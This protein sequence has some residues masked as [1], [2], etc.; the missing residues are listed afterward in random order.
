MK[1]NMTCRTCEFGSNG[2][3]KDDGKD[4]HSKELIQDDI[5]CDEWGASLE[6]YSEITEN[7][8][9]Y[10]KEPYK[11]C[12]ISYGEFLEFLRKDGEGIGININ[13]YDAI[14]RVYDLQPWELAG[15]LDVSMGVI[16]YARM[17]KTTVKRKRQFSS[18]LHIPEIFFDNFSSIQLEELKKCK[19]ECYEF[20]GSE[21]MKKFKQNGVNAMDLKMEQDIAKSKL[22]N[23]EYR[24]NSQYKYQYEGKNKMYHDLSDDYKARDYVIAITLKDGDYFGNIF[25]EYSYGGYGLSVSIMQDILAFIDNLNCEEIDGLNEEGLLSN[26]IGLKSDINGQEIHFELKNESGDVLRKK[27]PE[28]ELQKYIIGYEMIRCDGHGMKKERRRCSSCKNFYSIEGCAKGN[29]S[30]RGDVV[31]RSRVICAFDYVSIED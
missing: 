17:Q 29:C 8:P 13:I 2:F 21:S 18:R 1:L 24:K 16:G 26:N 5:S 27:I 4:E 10:I 12:Q 28:T 20:Y 25:Y 23:E 14:E 9:W 15:V 11:K 31:Q 30:V 19:E 6:Y 7:A 22:L 3:C